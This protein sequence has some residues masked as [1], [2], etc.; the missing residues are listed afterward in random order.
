M[1][2]HQSFSSNLIGFLVALEA[3]RNFISALESFVWT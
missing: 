3:Q 2:Y 1:T